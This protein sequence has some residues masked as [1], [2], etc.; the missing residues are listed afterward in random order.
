MKKHLFILTTLLVLTFSGKLVMAQ[1]AVTGAGGKMSFFICSDKTVMACGDNQF[2]QLGD[3][4]TINRTTPVPI[5]TLTGIIDIAVGHRHT[6]F[7]KNDGTVWACGEGYF[8]QLGDDTYTDRLTPVQVSSLTGIIAISAGGSDSQAHSLFLKNDGTAWACGANF[9]G[10]LG[11]AMYANAWGVPVP[12]TMSGGIPLSG[13]TSVA[14]GQS[15]SLFLKNDGIVWACGNNQSGQLGNGTNAS[16]LQCYSSSISNVAAIAAGHWHSLFIK[17]DATAWACGDNSEGSLGDGTQ[18]QNSTPAKVNTLSGITKIAAGYKSSSFLK[19]DGT[20]WV[21][22]AAGGLGTGAPATGSLLPV[23]VPSMSGINNISMGPWFSLFTKS[24]GT[25]WATGVNDVGQLGDGTLVSQYSPVHITGL[26]IV[27][28][29]DGFSINNAISAYPNPSSGIINF[30]LPQ[31]KTYSINIIDVTGKLMYSSII[32]QSNNM[33]DLSVFGKGL[34][35]VKITSTEETNV[36][37]I[38]IK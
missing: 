11:N 38:A 17:N 12:V 2:G 22:G 31:G 32:N 19:N 6:L 27:S 24:D 3:G 5:T 4:T 16:S 21:C 28:S 7:L 10:Q 9:S 26:C 33:V 25:F 20:V 34:Y 37:S 36:F 29:V 15:H 13:I 1:K 35:I 18:T 23:Q 14:A 30:N 8:G